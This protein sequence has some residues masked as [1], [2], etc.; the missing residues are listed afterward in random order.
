MGL[1]WLRA[2]LMRLTARTSGGTGSGQG[3]EPAAGTGAARGAVLPRP[4]ALTGSLLLD[5]GVDTAH[6][7]L[8]VVPAQEGPVRPAHLSQLDQGVEV[9]GAG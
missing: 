2:S 5:L 7:G 3:A 1:P 9:P 6:G 8:K 4:P